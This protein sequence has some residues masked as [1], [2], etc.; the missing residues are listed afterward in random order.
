MGL[1]GSK[2]VKWAALSG[3]TL[4]MPCFKNPKGKVLKVTQDFVHQLR[5]QGFEDCF[6]L[7]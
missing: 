3:M 1:V 2:G 6:V 7:L 5:S 4:R